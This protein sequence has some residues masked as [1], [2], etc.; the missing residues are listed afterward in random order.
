[1][2]SRKSD[3]YELKGMVGDMTAEQ[4]AEVEQVR[5]QILEMVGRSELAAIG[6]TLAM[7][8]LAEKS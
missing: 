7:M 5:L 8:L 1:M 6:I 2:N 3:Y 4:Q